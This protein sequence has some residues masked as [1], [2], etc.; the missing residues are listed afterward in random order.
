M[1]EIVMYWDEN[2][3]LG[4]PVSGIRISNDS[5]VEIPAQ[6]CGFRLGKVGEPWTEP[7]Y[8]APPGSPDAVFSFQGIEY[9]SDFV[10]TS[11]SAIEARGPVGGCAGGS[12]AY[13]FVTPLNSLGPAGSNP[14]L[15][16]AGSFHANF[17]LES[18][19]EWLNSAGAVIEVELPDPPIEEIELPPEFFEDVPSVKGCVRD[20]DGDLHCPLDT[21]SS[22]RPAGAPLPQ[23]GGIALLIGRNRG[24]LP[25]VGRATALAG[26]PNIIPSGQSLEVPCPSELHLTATFFKASGF[27]PAIVFYRFV[28]AH[29]PV[30]TRFS[31]LV[32]QDGPNPVFHSVPI[33]LPTPNSSPSQGGVGSASTD[34]AVYEPPIDPTGPSAG[35]VSDV[36]S[37]QIEPLP[38]NEHKGSVRVEILNVLDGILASGWASYHIVCSVGSDRP[39]VTPGLIGPSVVSLQAAINPWLLEKGTVPLSIDGK[40]GPSTAAAVRDFQ[41][42]QELVADGFVGPKT[43]RALLTRSTF[44][45]KCDHDPLGHRSHTEVLN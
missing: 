31:T 8:F 7:W 43:W 10:S 45:D 34:I 25:H 18:D 20:S 24:I 5:E 44:A 6:A 39:R 14:V 38:E 42:A 21:D 13:L 17:T 23:A 12:G 22:G 4:D 19:I 3:F 29:G 15:N 1:P 30:S 37:L 26:T 28:F 35:G 33:P 36:G 2:N 41:R 27:D 11:P 40:F 32:D 16:G 9:A